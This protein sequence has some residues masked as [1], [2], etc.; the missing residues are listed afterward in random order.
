ME[1]FRP[2]TGKSKK[3]RIWLKMAV[4]FGSTMLLLLALEGGLRIAGYATS[5]A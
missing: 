4:A 1:P 2:M 3:K 5:P